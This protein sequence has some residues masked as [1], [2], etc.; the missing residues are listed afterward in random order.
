MSVSWNDVVLWGF[1]GT[2]AM[3]IVMAGTQGLGLI[4]DQSAVHARH[5]VHAG[6]RSCQAYR[7]RGAPAERLV[8]GH[9]LRRGIREL[10][11]CVVVARS[12]N[13]PGSR[14]VRARGGDAADAGTPHLPDGERTAWPYANQAARA[15]GFL[16]LHYG[17][18][19]PLSVILA[20]LIYGGILGTFYRLA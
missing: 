20:H 2:A 12:R 5:D 4:A 18:R 6:S 16:A 15:A 8:V 9:R 13:W 3:T 7:L 1:V 17:G 10:G 11:P 19:T 14:A